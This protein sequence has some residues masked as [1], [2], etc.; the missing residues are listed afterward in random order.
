MSDDRIG[1]GELAS[2][3]STDDNVV[4]AFRT[5]KSSAV[6]RL[7]RLGDA[8]DEVLSRHAYPE[9][10]SRVLGEALALTAMLGTQLK[11]DGRL[12]LQ[13][14]TDGPLRVLVINYQTGANSFRGYASFDAEA[15]AA[16]SEKN[17]KI[18]DR[19]LIGTG[20]MALTIDPG[21]DMER[22][23]GIVQLEGSSLSVAAQEYFRQSEQIPSFI[24]L[25]VA[26]LFSGGKWRWRA[27]GLMVQH[28]TAEGGIDA[29]GRDGDDES[30]LDT[31][32]HEEN[33]RRVEMLARTVEDHELT[34]PMLS[35]Q[36]LLYR[37]FH[38]EGVRAAPGRSIEARCGCNRE[39]VGAFLKRFGVE[40]LAD[41]RETDGGV[42]VT[43]E[44]CSTPYRFSEGDLG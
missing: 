33:W 12:I 4:I 29:P 39:H 10:V 11:F 16:L 15:I 32:P 13:T 30:D 40:E 9:A 17:S 27:G 24:K 1:H 28:L 6:G 35:P 18:T 22:Y 42:T 44:F 23:Q 34:D 37:L 20:Y 25:S 5:E 19:D 38:E 31:P 2:E 43:C 14:N 8:V 7:I 21:E 3:A 36:L 26:K 41:L